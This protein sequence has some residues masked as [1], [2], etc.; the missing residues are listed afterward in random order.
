MS[1]SEALDEARDLPRASGRKVYHLDRKR[2]PHDL[3]PSFTDWNWLIPAR[4]MVHHVGVGSETEETGI[5]ITGQGDDLGPIPSAPVGT[6]FAHHEDGVG[7]VLHRHPNRWMREPAAKRE[8]LVVGPRQGHLDLFLSLCGCLQPPYAVLYVLSA[9]RA[10]EPGRYQL[11]S[12]LD[13]P[14]LREF[15]APYREFFQGDARHHLWIF[16]HDSSATIVYDKHDLIYAYGPLDQFIEV[17]RQHGLDEG[18]F[19]LPYPHYH[20][21]FPEFDEQERALIQEN[22]WKRTPIVPGVDD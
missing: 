4:N 8:R 13:L 21:Y 18:E 6:K 15:V 1:S 17:L 19:E 11:E 16:S 10:S 7:Q 20:N 9:P 12:W 22:R 5:T 3:R 14:Q 2:V